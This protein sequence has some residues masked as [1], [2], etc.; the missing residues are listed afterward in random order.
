MKESLEVEIV[1]TDKS[2]CVTLLSGRCIGY[3]GFRQ[4]FVDGCYDKRGFVDTG[5]WRRFKKSMKYFGVSISDKL[6]PKFLD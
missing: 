2:V 5:D 3:F 1:T 4:F 6:K